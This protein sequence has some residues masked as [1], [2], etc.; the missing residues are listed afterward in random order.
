MKAVEMTLLLPDAPSLRP[1]VS[2]PALHSAV[3]SAKNFLLKKKSLADRER[4]IYTDNLEEG[5][6]GQ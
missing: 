5:V 4:K 6:S 1:V 3:T 2:W